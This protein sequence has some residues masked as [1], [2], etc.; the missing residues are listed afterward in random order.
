MKG[1]KR[2]DAEQERRHLRLDFFGKERK[3]CDAELMS[4]EQ[5]L[6]C[7]INIPINGADLILDRVFDNVEFN[8]IDD[9]VYDFYG[10]KFLGHK[11]MRRLY[12]RSDFNGYPF[13][14]DYDMSPENN[15]YTLE[16]DPEPDYTVEYNLNEDGTLSETKHKLFTDCSLLGYRRYRGRH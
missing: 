7:I 3:K 2:I 16:D 14:K 8:R 15:K 1:R 13:R 9:E 4:A 11:D 12:L 5:I 6:S 10:I